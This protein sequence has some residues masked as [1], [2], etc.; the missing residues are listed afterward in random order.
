MKL[1]VLTN[2]FADLSL[3]E[4]LSKLESLGVD[5]AEIGCGGY[6]GKA[7]CNPKALLADELALAEFRA[8]FERHGIELACLSVHGNAVHPN[9]VIAKQFHDDFTDAV[10]LAEKLGVDTVVTFSGCPGGSPEDKTPNWV[11]CP[12]PDDFLAVL[13]YQWNQ[14]LIPYWKKAGAFAKEHGVTKI[15]F[16]MHPG[17]CVYNPETLLKLREA[18]GDVIGA[19]F[20]PSHLIWQGIEPVAAIRALEG[21]IY[22]FHAKDTKV[23]KYNVAKFGVLDTKHYSDEIHR[24]WVFRSVGYGNGLDYWRDIISNLRLVGYDKVMSI[25]HED[26]LMTPEEGLLHALEFLK[27]SNIRQPKPTTMGWA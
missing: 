10:L 12:W 26:S 20:D 11:T 4:V 25:E 15:A 1:G 27:E 9:P 24:S 14:V 8:A 18:V 2:L 22:H 5:A 3:E 7:H 23:D 19:N 13:D 6:P 21:A 17:F 16:E